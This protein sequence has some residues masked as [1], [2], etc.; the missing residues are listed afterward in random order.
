MPFGWAAAQG[1]GNNSPT[2]PIR[3][4]DPGAEHKFEIWANGDV[5]VRKFGNEAKREISGVTN[6]NWGRV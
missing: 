4:F 2:T 6:I 3:T 1:Q 5:S